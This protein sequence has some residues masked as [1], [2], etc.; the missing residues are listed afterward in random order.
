VCSF[1][2]PLLSS[3]SKRVLASRA[4][5]S[6]GSLHF[7]PSCAASYEKTPGRRQ[8][9]TNV[10]L[11]GP[12]ISDPIAVGAIECAPTIINSTSMLSDDQLLLIRKTIIVAIASDDALM[13]RLVLKGGN[14][15]DIVYRLGERASLDVDFSMSDDFTSRAELESVGHRLFQALRDRF[16][17]IDLIVFDERLEERPRGQ[18]GPGIAV[19]GGYNATFKLLSRERF[20]ALGGSPGVPPTGLLLEAMQ[21]ESLNAGAGAG[22]TRKFTIEI[23][24]FEYCEGRVLQ[25]VDD[26]DCYVYTPAM[27]A[28]EKLR[29][30]CQ[31]LPTYAQRKN[32]T[33]RPRD[34]L[35]IHT[36]ETRGGCDLAAAEHH[37]LLRSMFAVKEVPLNLIREIGS[38]GN[39]GFH[40]Q[41]WSAVLDLVRG[42][43]PHRFDFYFDYV[44][45][46]GGRI[47]EALEN[48]SRH[49]NSAG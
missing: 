46:L 24:K 19:W 32:P 3:S 5:G 49:S 34:F 42:T 45:E 35:D 14:A 9:Q 4:Y 43:L 41:Q 18:G 22:T 33:P 10:R 12:R 13:E 1:L 44:V 15:L 27:I 47:L 25:S 16:D 38:E 20:Y 37:S 8:A 31:Q 48:D 30:I 23:S 36:I 2:P 29:A 26:Y 21:R 28:A 39:R 40:A 7:G 17:A 6:G 11:Y